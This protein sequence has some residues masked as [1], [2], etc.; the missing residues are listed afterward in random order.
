M[1][2]RIFN[3]RV[4][5]SCLLVLPLL[6]SASAGQQGAAVAA[7]RAAFRQWLMSASNSPLAAVAQRRID[8]GVSLGPADADIPLAGLGPHTL[9]ERDG[10]VTLTAPDGRAR[11]VPRGRLVPLPPYAL[12][13]SGET[14]RT[15]VTVFHSPKGKPPEW[16]AYNPALVFEGPIAAA[17]APETSR[18]LTLDGIEVE[19]SLAG[20]VRLPL[21]EP[22]ARLRV[23][24]MPVPGTEE[25]ELQ[26]Y[27]RDETSGKGTYPAGRFVE[28]T[29][30]GDGRYRV[31]LNRARNPF[32][33]YSSV[34]ACPL[35]WPGNAIHAA[36][37]AGEK[38]A[39]GGLKL[40]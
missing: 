2:I 7:E 19:A 29:P 3:R 36:V 4:R 23:L 17:P 38:Y 37:T 21:G 20:Y 31:D 13:L 39:G 5:L 32:C 27:F 14:G 11:P 40:E 9:R 6:P 15:T 35:P 28:V 16:Y 33:A 30:I 18:V 25:F 24:R 10:S 22:A 1:P 34:Y 8:A 12:T 26:V